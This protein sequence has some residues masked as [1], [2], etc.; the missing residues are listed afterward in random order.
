MGE[1]F[2]VIPIEMQR[3]QTEV[4]VQERKQHEFKLIGHQRRIPGHTLF[5]VNIKTGEINVAPVD[6]SKAVDFKTGMPTYRERIV[7]EPNCL[8]RQALNRKNFIKKLKRERVIVTRV[9]KEG[10]VIVND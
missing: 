4:R 6:R 10:D 5:C 9:P 3:P 8:Y 2:E 7:V 1:I